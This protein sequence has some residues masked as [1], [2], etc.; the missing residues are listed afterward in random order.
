MSDTYDTAATDPGSL[1]PLT[2]ALC[3]TWALATS[4]DARVEPMPK[5]VAMRKLL[6]TINALETRIIALE[7]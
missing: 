5:P 1:P 3:A 6:D 7:S 4:V 2:A